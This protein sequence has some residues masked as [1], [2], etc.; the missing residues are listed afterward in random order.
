VAKKKSKPPLH[1]TPR[2]RARVI[3][4]FRRVGRVDLA[5]AHAGCDRSQHYRWL[6]D[7]P[8]YAKA[9]DEAR[10]QVNGLLEDEAIRR[11]YHGTPKPVAVAG[12]VIYEYEFSDRLL[13]F[14]LKCRNPAVFGDRQ[15]LEHSGELALTKRLIGVNVEDI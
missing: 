10:E 13:E 5:C 2:T 6:R 7:D 3:E 11:A 4:E 1:H 8:E 15:K 14:L 12:K 9:F